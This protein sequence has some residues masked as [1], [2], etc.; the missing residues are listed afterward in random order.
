MIEKLTAEQES[1]FPHYVKKWID[2]GL[3][4]ST[5]AVDQ[6]ACREAID[7]CYAVLKL[8]PPKYIIHLDGPTHGNFAA[9]APD[10]IFEMCESG[11]IDFNNAW[12]SIK[13]IKLPSK[14]TFCEPTI[15]G[16]HNAGFLSFYDFFNE[17]FGLAEE[18]KGLVKLSK[19]ANWCW[20]FSDLAIVTRN[21][22]TMS[23]LDGRLHSEVGPAIAYADGTEVYS[24]FGTVVPKKWVIEKNTISPEI[25]LAERD[26]DKRAIGIKLIGYQRMKDKL[27]Y[28]I[29]DGDPT[30]DIGAL[31]ELTIPDLPRPGRF[32]EAICPRNGS[33]FLGV[34]TNNPVDSKAITTAIGAQAFLAR[35]PTDAYVHPKIRT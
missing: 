2:I 10:Q 18:I 8:P 7:E 27:N 12:E 24:V 31:I 30:T 19:L 26:T 34:P 21:P 25:I 17:Q 15:Y 33:V 3:A 1:L 29:I 20:T 9:N 28:K 22:T 13:N 23:M 11:E 32:L 5:G 35:L 4:K 14:Q 16:S 6:A